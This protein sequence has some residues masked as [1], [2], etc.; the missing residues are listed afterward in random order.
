VD[1]EEIITELDGDEW[2]SATKIGAG[3][4]T[5]VRVWIDTVEPNYYP[6]S[7][8]R[9]QDISD[10]PTFVLNCSGTCAADSGTYAGVIIKDE[11]GANSPTL[12]DFYAGDASPGAKRVMLIY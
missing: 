1:S 10:T 2:L 5:T 3:S 4:N 8:D 9:W 12:D 11:T 6:Y 7:S